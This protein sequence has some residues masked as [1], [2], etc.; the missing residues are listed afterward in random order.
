[1]GAEAATPNLLFAPQK[2]T[3]IPTKIA[4]GIVPVK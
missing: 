2:G 1:M 3:P 4:N